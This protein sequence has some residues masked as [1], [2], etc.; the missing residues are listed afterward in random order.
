MF[1]VRKIVIFILIVIGF[2]ITSAQ[3]EYD[4]LDS[5]SYEDFSIKEENSYGTKSS[6]ASIGSLFYDKRKPGEP[7]ALTRP[8]G[9]IIS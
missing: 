7:P 4:G 9:I 3:Y 8:N 6:Y 2:T 1:S 5:D